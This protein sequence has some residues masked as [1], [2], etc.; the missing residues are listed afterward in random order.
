MM[1]ITQ[2]R[3]LAAHLR[4][5]SNPIVVL[6]V[7]WGLFIVYG[8]L[9]PFQFSVNG[10]YV[11]AGL[12]RIWEYPWHTGSR[13]DLV[14]NVLLFMP[15][16][17]LL[18]T[19]RSTCGSGFLAALVLA[20]L[21][22]FLLSGA[23]E[24][25]QLFTPSRT[26]SL[27]DLLTNTAG[28]TLGAAIGW[29]FARR[30]WPRMVGKLRQLTV[31]RPLTAC[32][33]AVAAGLTVTALAPFDISVQVSELKSAIKN[34]RLVPFGPTLDGASEPAKAWPLASDLLIWMLAGGLF[35]LAAREAGRRG[36][37]AILLAVL[38]AVGLCLATELMQLVIPSHRS[39]MTTVVMALIGS[40]VGAVSL[41]RSRSRYARDWIAPTLCIWAGIAALKF[42]APPNFAAPGPPY[43]RPE[44]FVP[45]WSYYV[46][47]NAAALG[48]V[49]DQVLIFI[50][51]GALLAAAS[52]R[53]SVL[54]AA[55]IG[56]TVGLILEVGQ[57]F[58]P[59]RTAEL[60]DALSASVGAGLGLALLR[61]GESV[62]DP[63]SSLGVTRYRVGSTDDE[64]LWPP[65]VH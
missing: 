62:R 39:D 19:W 1:M 31:E 60:T 40:T 29:P 36:G 14:S 34:A 56:F 20:L 59:E 10:G 9:L 61:W 43:L 7:L 30:V 65:N 28:S 42:W 54:Q 24:C 52:R 16:G 26:A 25:A 63:T 41:V 51:L 57:V 12:R 50:P 38:A 32:A 22:G 4:W 3:L 48:D 11:E 8:T 37:Q 44:W 17:F 2:L 49:I 23:V 58:L 18:A 45:F 27:L 46:R 5:R 35:A 13:A 21:S 53:R 15:W 64:K 47:T 6:L 33:L 55:V